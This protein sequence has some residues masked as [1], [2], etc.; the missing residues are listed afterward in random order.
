MAI[1][2]VLALL[3]LPVYLSCR[4][5]KWTQEHCCV[6]GSKVELQQVLEAATKALTATG[7]YHNDVRLLRIWVQYVSVCPFCFCGSLLSWRCYDT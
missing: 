2:A 5:I 7:R 4:Y 3:V 6:Q 1:K